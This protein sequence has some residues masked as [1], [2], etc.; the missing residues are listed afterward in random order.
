MGI[1]LQLCKKQTKSTDHIQYGCKTGYQ[2]VLYFHQSGCKQFVLWCCTF[3]SYSLTRFSTGKYE[4]K[5]LKVLKGLVFP[6]S[7]T[8]TQLRK[9]FQ[10][11]AGYS[12][13]ILFKY[14]L[15]FVFPL[16]LKISPGTKFKNVQP[17]K[18]FL[19][20]EISI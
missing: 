8:L 20:L 2:A 14:L 18:E 12:Q 16:S 6:C 9:F 13:Y 10:W 15:N 4:I 5:H 7:P 19:V 1:R 17:A 11:I 3:V